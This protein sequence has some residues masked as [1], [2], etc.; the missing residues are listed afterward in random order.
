MTRPFH[1]VDV[2]GTDAFTGNPVAVISAAEGLTTAEMQSITRWMNLSETTFLLPPIHPD[3]DYRVRI[4][5]LAHELPFAGHPT[6]GTAHV[7]LETGGRSKASSSVIQECAAGLIQLQR[8]EGRL[9]FAA[10]KLLK[11]GPLSEAEIHEVAK[12]LRIDR[13]KIQEAVWA[14]N[15]PGW[16]AVMLASAK[17]VLEVN[18]LRSH[19]HNVEIGVVGP[20]PE[21]SETSFEIRAFFSDA[22]GGVMEDPVT[23]SLNASVGQWLF[24][25]GRVS[26][27]YIASQGTK[28]GRCG[29]IYVSQDKTGQV[30]VG[31]NTKT[32]F[33]G[34]G[35][36]NKV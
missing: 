4:F 28:L 8:S 30:W 10:P 35:F 1:L 13:A 20:C 7:W 5:T 33:S 11:D 16:I 3:A 6:L 27:G 31:G 17:A 14:D 19:E 22:Q 18:P 25:S 32:L 15:G 9:A 21:S 26:S 24:S 2:F 34:Q 36:T 12:I 23:G 29:R